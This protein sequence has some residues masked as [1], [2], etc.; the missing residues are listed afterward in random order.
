MWNNSLHKHYF[1][2]HFKNKKENKTQI[3]GDKIFP[4]PE[5]ANKLISNHLCLVCEAVRY[6]RVKCGTN[7]CP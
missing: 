4:G 5:N 6:L 7:G 3:F 1:L 2:S